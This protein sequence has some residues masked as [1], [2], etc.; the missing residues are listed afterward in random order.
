[1]HLLREEGIPIGRFNVR[2]LMID[3][4]LVSKQPGLPAYPQVTLE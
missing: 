2:M 4:G 1:M 3:M